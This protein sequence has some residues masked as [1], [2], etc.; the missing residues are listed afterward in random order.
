LFSCLA[1]S[2]TVTGLVVWA[3]FRAPLQ[4]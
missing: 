2:P 3:F 1:G 4:P